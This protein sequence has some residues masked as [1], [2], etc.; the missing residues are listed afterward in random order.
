[1]VNTPMKVARPFSRW[2]GTMAT[3]CSSPP[4]LK[5]E[6]PPMSRPE[7]P[8]PIETTYASGASASVARSNAIPGPAAPI[9]KGSGDSGSAAGRR[10][11]A[12]LPATGLVQA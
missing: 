8:R 10:R 5:V 2:A 1:M 12:P 7:C 9:V 4:R 11:K 3:S 6:H